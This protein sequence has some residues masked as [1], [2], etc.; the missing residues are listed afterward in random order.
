MALDDI[1][2]WVP[3]SLPLAVLVFLGLYVIKAFIM[4]PPAPVMYVAAGIVF[5]TG[6]AIAVTYFCTAVNISL[7]YLNGKV[8]GEKRVRKWFANK[9]WAADL[10]DED[11]KDKVLSA[12]FIVRL[13]PV[14]KDA[15]S[16]FFGAVS[17]P[18]TKYFVASILG[19]TPMLI[20]ITLA[21]AFID[22]PLSPEFLVP[23]SICLV[24]ALVM[25]IV[26]KRRIKRRSV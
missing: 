17:M 20:P 23:F 22:D 16:L 12:C 19:L 1:L 6:W 26:Y 2:N 10:F 11:K 21:G 8:L 3:P 25:F 7:A 15:P 18:F 13:L 24:F 4:M 14:P 5:P 9:K